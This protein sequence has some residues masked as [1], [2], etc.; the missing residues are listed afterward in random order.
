MISEFLSWT[1]PRGDNKEAEASMVIAL[2]IA[3]DSKFFRIAL[4]QL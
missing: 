2:S 4:P 3:E 1:S